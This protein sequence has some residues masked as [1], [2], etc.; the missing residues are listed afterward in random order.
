M[1]DLRKETIH[2]LFYKQVKDLTL[3]KI[4]SFDL[5]FSDAWLWNK[6]EVVKMEEF[7]LDR[8][9]YTEEGVSD[10]SDNDEIDPREEGFMQ[11]YLAS[12]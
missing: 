8:D 10:Y 3:S 2:D 4:Q 1:V 5:Q 11:G 9:I 6:K 7:E 12:V